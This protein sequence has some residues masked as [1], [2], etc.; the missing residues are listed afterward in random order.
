MI[1]KR[2]LIQWLESLESNEVGIDN[3]GLSLVDSNGC[4]CEV[5][6]YVGPERP[7]ESPRQCEG[8]D[9]SGVRP[10]STNHSGIKIPEGFVAVER[11]DTCGQYL[12]DYAAAV[13]WG[14]DAGLFYGNVVIARPPDSYQEER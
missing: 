8:C 11:C 9:G 4:Y 14:D 13:A 5:G 10:D 1:D 12:S 7:L 2:E 6:G 3:G